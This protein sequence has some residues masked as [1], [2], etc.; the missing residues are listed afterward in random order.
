VTF[1]EAY[2]NAG[3]AGKTAEFKITVS[4]VKRK[5]LPEVN[6]EFA[7]QSGFDNV[8]AMREKIES[9]LREGASSQGNAIAEG[10]AIA[11]IIEASTF[12]LPK[13]LV[14]ASAQDYAE[15][16]RRRL[17]QLRVP[18]SQIAEQEEEILKNAREAALR[19]IKAFAVI[20][21]IG[22]AEGIA[23]S[24]EDYEV[25]AEQLL[26]RTGMQLDVESVTR[27][28]QQEDRQGE[29]EG[30]IFR[31]KALKVI[32]DN[33]TITDKVVTREQLETE[34]V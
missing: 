18:A 21:E 7:T 2:S 13:S 10:R 11:K 9:D 1:P 4:E 15:Q 22:E 25:E 28:I 29:Y 31:R 3:L 16:E 12:E 6:D 32:M 34:T 17:M 33:A 14:E 20:N 30:R 5:S 24:D 27:Y 19:D 8:A 26:Q 23:V